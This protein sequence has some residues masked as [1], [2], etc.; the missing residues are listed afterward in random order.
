[1]VYHCG[2]LE[3]NPIGGLSEKHAFEL[4]YQAMGVY[5]VYAQTS[6]LSRRLLWAHLLHP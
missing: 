6:I 3:L 5:D 1:M 2:Q 4:S